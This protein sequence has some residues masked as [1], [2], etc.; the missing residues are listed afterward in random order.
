MRNIYILLIVT[1]TMFVIS[2]E[3]E[4]TP[5]L[6]QAEDRIVIEGII[7]NGQYP[8]VF[9]TKNLS[10]FDAIDSTL[11]TQL[12]VKDAT[13]IVSDGTITDTLEPDLDFFHM[14]FFGYKGTSIIGEVG[15]TYKLEVIYQGKSYTG[16]AYIPELVPID[17]MAFKLR[18]DADTLGHIW[19]SAKDPDTLGNFYRIF[20]KTLD[21][22]FAFVHP[23]YSVADDQFINGQ[24]LETTISR[25]AN[26][27]MEEVEED[28]PGDDKKIPAEAF[29]IGETV[30][31]KFCTMDASHY[32]FWYS[33]EQQSASGGNPF[34]SPTTVRTNMSGGAIGVWGG[35]GVVYDTI[36][37]STED[38]IE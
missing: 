1:V 15:K 7:E 20:T 31:L 22:D 23:A 29:I 21:K 37:I 11:L 3:K 13:V 16:N 17:S 8:H 2:C 4:I 5:S 25:G 32:D 27:M 6:P 33:I 30:I 12:T 36:H 9:V 28:E 18:Y 10:Y 19:F 34:A 14:P 35:Y 26:P 24:S 38:I